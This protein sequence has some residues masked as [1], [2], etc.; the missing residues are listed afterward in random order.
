M[1]E[2]SARRP[3]DP[4]D[5]LLLRQERDPRRRTIITV[6][7]CLDSAPEW[8]ALVARVEL[9][10]R[11]DPKLRQRVLTPLRGA[12]PPEWV[13]DTDFDVRYHLR[14]ARLP[15]P[16]NRAQLLEYAESLAPAPLDPRRP[17]W[18]AILVESGQDNTAALLIRLSHALVDGLAGVELLA[19][20]VDLQPCPVVDPLSVPDV[21]DKQVTVLRLT[22]ERV[23]AMPEQARARALRNAHET[24]RAA[25][26]ILDNPRGQARAALGYA[27]SLGR[28][29]SPGRAAA[30]PA[31]RERSA[32]RRFRTLEIPA[33][34]LRRAARTVG[35]SLNDAYLAGVL[36]GL[37]HYHEALGLEVTEM[38]FAVPVSTRSRG[39][40]S[41]DGAGNRFAPVRFAAPV[42]LADPGERI[43]ALSAIVRAARAEPALDA[44]TTLAPVLAQLPS[45]ML[46]LAGRAQDRLDVQ[47]SYVPGPPVP[48]YLA[49]REVV[50]IF[51]LGPLPG[52]AIMTVLLTYA[53]TCCIGFTIDPASVTDLAL[54]EKCA[55]EGFAEVLALADRD[56]P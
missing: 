26:N 4:V 16:G 42:G 9:A 50:R 48:V 31:L 35:G 2:S 51:A 49:G 17:L 18:E 22:V 24:L 20:L 10:I 28:L 55:Q 6:A 38:P 40:G 32:A 15:E 21:A 30:S 52:P 19:S 8:A 45:P 54:F 41:N 39:E 1:S 23:L 34:Q 37:R 14:R 27:R 25:T 3:V 29:L 12:G 43:R 7:L 56:A 5:V 47:A 13:T 33:Q 53:S 44:M 46:A 36:G 11:M